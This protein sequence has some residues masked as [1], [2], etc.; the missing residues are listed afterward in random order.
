MG[1]GDR[2]VVRRRGCFQLQ[3]VRSSGQ[4]AVFDAQPTVCDEEVQLS[5]DLL[6]LCRDAAYFDFFQLA[7]ALLCHCFQCQ[8]TGRALQ[9]CGSR[10]SGMCRRSAAVSGDGRLFLFERLTVTVLAMCIKDTGVVEV[11][12][13]ERAD[14][15]PSLSLFC[16]C[17]SL[18]SHQ[19][20]SS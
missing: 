15:T 3:S 8:Q 18:Y 20:D 11:R 17:C 10:R 16:L 1:G 2:Q 13:T 6:F 5:I 9:I 7:D 12:K 4:H 14:E 19:C